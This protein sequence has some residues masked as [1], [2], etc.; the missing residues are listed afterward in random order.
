MGREHRRRRALFGRDVLGQGLGRRLQ[1]LA[2][3]RRRRRQFRRR[4]GRGAA[5]EHRHVV[6]GILARE[7]EVGASRRLEGRQRRG[8]AVV[9]GVRHHVGEDLVPLPRAFRDQVLAPLEMA[10]DG[11][12]RHARVLR[13]LRQGKAGRALLLDQAQ[14]RVDQ[15]LLEVAVVIAAFGHAAQTPGA[16]WSDH[17][18]GPPQIDGSGWPTTVS[19]LPS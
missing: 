3:F 15:R 16:E 14:G 10:V 9:E 5:F 4:I 13:G 7:G 2:R 8:F 12:R 18:S 1:H 19:F 6:P 17:I 11:R